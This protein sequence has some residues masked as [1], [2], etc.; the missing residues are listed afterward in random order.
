MRNG[1]YRAIL[2]MAAIFGLV[3]MGNRVSAQSSAPVL[4]IANSSLL[5]RVFW[6]NNGYY[7]MLQT[8][9]TLTTTNPWHSFASGFPLMYAF[10][11]FTGT[12][13]QLPTATATNNE[14]YFDQPKYPVSYT[15]LTLP[16][17]LRV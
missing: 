15:H 14:F 11:Y 9:T 1:F 4:R 10:S 5:A 13:Y 3:T 8:A 16:T 7:H 12:F 2:L 6:S 17:I